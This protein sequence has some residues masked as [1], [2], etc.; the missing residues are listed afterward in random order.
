MLLKFEASTRFP[1]NDFLEVALCLWL[2][3]RKEGQ[4]SNISSDSCFRFTGNYAN[5]DANNNNNDSSNNNKNNNNSSSSSNSGGGSINGQKDI[6]YL[7]LHAS[8]TVLC[9]LL[10]CQIIF[11]KQDCPKMSHPTGSS[12]NVML[13]F[14]EIWGLCSL[15]LYLAN[16]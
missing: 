13:T 9:T 5:N 16:L 15:P 1:L 12:S 14:I 11:L 10:L 3:P 2:S 6:I 4:A 7:V 8:G